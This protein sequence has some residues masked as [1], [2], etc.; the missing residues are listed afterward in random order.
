M[1]FK[2]DENVPVELAD[3]LRAAGYDA[4]TVQDEGLR[5]FS[6]ERLIDIA[7]RDGRVLIT[8]DVGIGDIRAFPPDDF[9]GIVLLRPGKTGGKA[10]A[11]FARRFLLVILSMELDRRLVVVTEQGVR[12]RS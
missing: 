3:D 9:S 10:I 2:L 12:V 11:Q 6:D 1:K 8:L 7:S 4:D 5:G